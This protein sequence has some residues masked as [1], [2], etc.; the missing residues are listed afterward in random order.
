MGYAKYVGRIGALAF[1][2]GVGIG[3]GASPAV[4]VAEDTTG[5]ASDTSASDTTST[6][7]RDSAAD[8]DA[9]AD[10]AH[11]GGGTTEDPDDNHDPDDSE[12]PDEPADSEDPDDVDETAEDP[13]DEPE[14]AEPEE[15]DEPRERSGS[16][17]AAEGPE[18]EPAAVVADADPV[19]DD[20][21]AEA[22]AEPGPTAEPAA[23]G[24]P[25][26]AGPTTPPAEETVAPTA[27]TV[28]LAGETPPPAP[29]SEAPDAP[30]A[31]TAL[32][33]ML[34]AARRETQDG[35]SAA[36]VP[37]G[38]V[39]AAALQNLIDIADIKLIAEFIVGADPS[40]IAV[41]KT[42]AYVANSGGKSITVINAIDGRTVETI[43]LASAPTA[44]A[45]TPDGSRVYVTSAAARKVFVIDTETNAVL[46]SITVGANPSGIAVS[47]TGKTVYV[48]N[49][50]RGTVSKISTAT[51]TVVGTVYGV[52]KGVSGIAVSVD[53]TVYTSSTSGAV[54]YFS[55]LSLSA[56]TIAGVTSGSVGLTIAPDGSRVFV[57]DPTGGVKIIDTA[58]HEVVDSITV[59]VG[60]PSDVAVSPD[61]TM[62]FVGKADDGKL[63]VYDIA[64][65]AEL[66]TVHYLP[67]LNISAPVMTLSPDGAYLYLTDSANDRVWLVQLEQPNPPPLV[68]E[69]V[70]N[71][72][73]ASGVVT[74]SVTV[75]DAVS[76][77][78][79]YVIGQPSKGKVTVTQTGTTFTFTYT[80]TAGARH[81]AAQPG[82]PVRD[83]F[84]LT[85]FDSGRGYTDVPI[86]V[87]I[88]PAN[89]APTATA[90][91]VSSWLS[92]RVYVTVTARD[93][94]K[95]VL[96]YGV[97]P[98]A[99]GGTVVANG[100]GKF[101]YTP[102]AEARHAAAKAGAT[103]ADKR[104]TFDVVVADGHGGVTTVTVTVKIKPGNGSPKVS[105]RTAASWLSA[106][107]YVTVSAT[108]A[109]KDSLTYT[110]SP[111]TKGGTVVAGARGRFTYTPTAAA[112]HDAAAVGATDADKQDSFDITV[113][114]GHGGVTTVT[115]TVKIK[116]ANAAPSTPSAKDLFTNLNTGVVTGKITSTD[117]EGDPLTF[118]GPI[119]T[120][121]GQVEVHDDG[122]FVYTPT[123]AARAAASKRFAPSWEKTD[124]FRV[125]IDDG[126]GGVRTLTVRVG[127]APLGHTNAAPTNG[128]YTAD[129]P[130]VA[131]GKV[132][133]TVS[134]TDP[135]RDALT[136]SGSGPT[137]K[138]SVLVDPSGTFVYT[139]SDAARHQAT[140]DNATPADKVDTFT[141]TVSDG[142]G[143]SLAV[144]VTV[145]VGPSANRVPTDG[146]YTATAD[147][148]TGVVEGVA[149]AT[150]ANNDPL[151]FSGS[152]TTT[153]G[154]VDVKTGGAFT[155][156]PRP[157][158]RAAAGA[159]G[160][161][162]A[163][164]QDTFTITVSD[165]HGGTLGIPVTVEIIGLAAL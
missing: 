156:T 27:A 128:S 67:Y 88:A 18:P 12:D 79:S 32:W 150:D 134:A 145:K 96:T 29:S 19:I 7:A 71:A 5:S 151:T 34:A 47:P 41:S 142:H 139:P 25:E 78:L 11:A 17:G 68:G 94:D 23:A 1:A 148:A 112:R 60:V 24:V 61:G 87:S 84:Q 65:K 16:R 73:N 77:T 56:K 26:A 62:L 74:G 33:T 8:T 104:D 14:E 31:S 122:S 160:A 100:K 52:A 121:R 161:T 107:V 35:G 85:I 39:F 30:L 144:P 75:I 116:P 130:V 3:L 126:H 20:E 149:T 97:T 114:D 135:E 118:T 90:R 36:A 51:N 55:P 82:G 4:A 45:I 44:L 80:P 37:A 46:R 15:A 111:T 117:V 42:H 119:A 9:T 72:P 136:Y 64:T 48:V 115:V 21:P 129:D 163:D 93:A 76:P 70:V 155:Y 162:A 154:S 2:L 92:S 110:A 58:A 147:P 59:A 124:S 143:G 6:P 98:T 81:A 63:S 137:S 125:T 153:K 141:I 22:P 38:T 10:H 133:G 157:A 101:I 105:T 69:P 95:D 102:T 86:F 66:T 113:D 54:S 164:K 140:A 89:A 83:L 108:D 165:G 103:E 152:T 106:A 53:G 146:S 123:E 13:E 40:D 158:A 131:S 99:K 91:A 49:S 43:S 132:A 138:G 127:I 159:V 57:A 50:D 120:R 109:D 28:E